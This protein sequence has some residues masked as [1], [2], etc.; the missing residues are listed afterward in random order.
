MTNPQL[1][2]FLTEKLK[3]I[4]LRS[5]TRQGCPLLTVIIQHSFGSPSHGN[6]RRKKKEKQSK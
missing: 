4:S 5:E 6:Q 3:A 1:T 2:S